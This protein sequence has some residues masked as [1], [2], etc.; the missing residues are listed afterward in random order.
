M[1]A[2]GLPGIGASCTAQNRAPP[3]PPFALGTLA[4]G[5]TIVHW[6]AGLDVVSMVH[7]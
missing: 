7:V 2:A 6:P 1:F 3:L 5:I 4:K